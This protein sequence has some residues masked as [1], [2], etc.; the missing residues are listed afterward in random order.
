MMR[1]CRIFMKCRNTR[2]RFED[3][4]FGAFCISERA[5]EGAMLKLMPL[6]KGVTAIHMALLE[7]RVKAVIALLRP[8]FGSIFDGF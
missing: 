3:K 6:P 5:A 4:A 2:K 1:S 8:G 7:P